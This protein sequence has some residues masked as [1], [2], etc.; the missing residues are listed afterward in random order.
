MLQALRDKSSG[1]VATVILGLLIVPFALF[2][3]NDYISGGAQNYAARIQT[4]PTWWKSAP[5]VWPVSMAWQDEE[6]TQQQFRERFEQMRQQERAQQGEAF[7]NKAFESPENKRKV[8]ESMIDERLMRMAPSESG[9]QV[10]AAAIRREIESIPDFHVDGRFNEQKYVAM[11]GSLNPPQ[12]PLSFQQRVR[13]DLLRNALVGKVALSAFTPRAEADRM[14][15]LWFERRDV[16]AV[17]IP[18]VA[19]VAPVSDAEI[20]ARY[21]SNERDYHAPETVAAEYIEVDPAK[22]TPAP[23]SE[24]DLRARYAAE[25]G[26]FGEAE[27]RQVSHILVPVAGSG[28]AAEKAAQDTANALAAQAR[29]GA[30]FATLARA[31]SGDAGSRASGGD[32]GWVNRDGAMP[33]PFEDAVFAMQA[34]GA[35]SAP[36]KTEAGWHVIQLREIKAGT[37]RAFEEVRAQLEQEVNDGA[38]E[39][40]Y[41][42]L[43]SALVDDLMKNPSGFAEAAAKHG[44]TVQKSGA[45]AR[46]GGEGIVAV[47]AVQAEMF[48]EERIQD[49][50]ASDPI[51]VGKGRSVIVR[52]VGHTPQTARPLAEVREQ[53]IADVRSARASNSAAD[54]AKAMA[55][56]V[57][58]GG[59]LAALAKARGLAIDPFQGVMR[60]MP[61]PT[62]EATKAIFAVA[63]PQAGK[64][65]AG[66]TPLPDGSWMVFRIDS[67]TPAKLEEIPEAQR[68]QMREQLTMASAEQ[69]AKAFIAELRKSR[70]I[71]IVESQL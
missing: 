68:A 3:I 10:P 33:K 61:A 25:R 42:D 53:V 28:A 35:I 70:R 44:L 22:V 29:G 19:D 63:R 59:D 23:A 67:A 24:A 43:L 54:A 48:S 11:L 31:N 71:N 64:V 65:S 20:A 27:Q 37:E 9:I 8:L 41:N 56:S 14:L 5:A 17:R 49:G 40:A 30:D 6:I 36:V 47:P 1:W 69:A 46:G 62:P 4:P 26:K 16:S 32:L 21:K 58:K 18:L 7:D 15:A 2:G 60:T 57:E 50:S 13:D 12:T 38:R 55:A 51:D 34:A 66:S 52:V 39:R 45:V